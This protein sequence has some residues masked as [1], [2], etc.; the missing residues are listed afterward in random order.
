MCRSTLLPADESNR[1][2]RGRLHRNLTLPHTEY[3]RQVSP[4]G[5]NVTAELRPLKNHGRIH[6]ADSKAL[7]LNH[8]Y[9]P[10]K[11]VK[12]IRTLPFRVSVRK[13][14]ADVPEGRCTEDRVN[15]R[16]RED[17]RI[18]VTEQPGIMVDTHATYYKGA[19]Y[20]QSM[21]VIS[22]TDSHKSVSQML[23]C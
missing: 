22:N 20:D 21:N 15:D 14:C 10:R 18:R 13:K 19:S 1:L 4:N 2:A 23:R 16:V 6:V 7:R 3:H 17:I 9:Y 8:I 11:Q 12:A 5:R